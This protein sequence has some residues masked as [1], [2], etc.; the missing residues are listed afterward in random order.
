M[1]EQILNGIAKELKNL[2]SERVKDFYYAIHQYVDDY[3]ES[4]IRTLIFKW[5]QLGYD[6]FDDAFPITTKLITELESV[7]DGVERS[8]D[9][10]ER[11]IDLAKQASLEIQKYIE[12]YQNDR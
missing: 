11:I 12:K 3:D 10:Y 1:R 2:S 5:N 6:N 8:R 4:S 7:Y 9:V